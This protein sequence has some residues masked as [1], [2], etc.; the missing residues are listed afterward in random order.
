[1]IMNGIFSNYLR[2][3][4]WSVFGLKDLNVNMIDADK[5][6]H[7]RQNMNFVTRSLHS[8]ANKLHIM[9]Q[10]ADIFG[11]NQ[12]TS[13]NIYLYHCI[14]EVCCMYHLLI[15][16]ISIY[17][18]YYIVLLSWFACHCCRRYILSQKRNA[19]SKPFFPNMN[20]LKYLR[21]WDMKTWSC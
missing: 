7:A 1:M 10:Q 4:F 3:M 5:Y 16:H 9:A 6:H 11:I 8:L 2:T 12:C 18:I 21:D 17:N 13:I 19:T 14:E 15:L 20:F